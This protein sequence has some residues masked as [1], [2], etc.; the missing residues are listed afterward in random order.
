MFIVCFVYTLKLAWKLGPWIHKH[1]QKWSTQIQ[2]WSRND[3][4]L[5]KIGMRM[6]KSHGLSSWHRLSAATWAI[7]WAILWAIPDLLWADLFIHRI[8]RGEA[9]SAI[10]PNHSRAFFRHGRPQVSGHGQWKGGNPT[11]L[12]FR[13]IT[14][15]AM[16]GP[17]H[18]FTQHSLDFEIPNI[19]TCAH[20]MVALFEPYPSGW[21]Y[22]LWSTSFFKWTLHH[23]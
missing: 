12:D 14:T 11:C 20:P 9:N 22:Y 1:A 21:W 4:P 3:F 19:A 6:P 8:R 5:V 10:F 15:A 17:T 2:P 18:I 23:F 16:Y 7:L 13:I